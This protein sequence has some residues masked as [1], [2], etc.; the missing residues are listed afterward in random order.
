MKFDER[1]LVTA[2]ELARNTSQLLAKVGEGRRLVI[3]HRNSPTAALIGI[4]DLRLLEELI[5]EHTGPTD[6]N[7]LR[8]GASLDQ[9]GAYLH[10]LDMP[11]LSSWDPSEAWRRNQT[12]TR[13]IPL[14]LSPRGVPVDL[15]MCD[16]NGTPHHGLIG[17][18]TGSGKSTALATMALSLCA[19]YSPAQVSFVLV[20]TKATFCGL[21]TLPHV[22]LFDTNK[23]APASVIDELVDDL[24]GI[25][26]SRQ[27]LAA[28]H[29]QPTLHHAAGAGPAAPV[30]FVVVDDYDVIASE[31]TEFGKCLT[32]IARRGQALSMSLV[33]AS[34]SLRLQGLYRDLRPVMSYL[35][36]LRTRDTGDSRELVGTGDAATLPLGGGA[37][38]I[39]TPG[40]TPSLSR[41]DF[42]DSTA[43]DATGEPIRDTIISRIRE[44]T[45]GVRGC[46]E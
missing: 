11:D 8:I 42:F 18:T 27:R 14:G 34:E 28:D 12:A 46:H 30:L 31:Y 6:F 7:A 20:G 2:T 38:I 13:T 22:R 37:A 3:I 35:I 25:A 33:L 43:P 15:A 21:D 24:N 10:A 23:G 40:D 5:Q 44:A 17:G 41:F 19:R 26:A 36:A 1:D 16:P 45:T 32:N 29:G 4:D 39:N 9:A